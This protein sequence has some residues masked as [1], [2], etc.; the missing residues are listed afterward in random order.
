MK[1]PNI[2]DM[3]DKIIT[4]ALAKAEGKREVAAFLLGMSVRTLQRFIAKRRQKNE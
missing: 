2:K 1:M 4:I 3:Q